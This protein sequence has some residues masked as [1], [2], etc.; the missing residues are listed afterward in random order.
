MCW[1]VKL[2]LTI[3]EPLVVSWSGYGRGSKAPGVKKP[4]VG[5][6][7]VAHNLIKAH[8]KVWH[9]YNEQ[10][11]SRQ[12]GEHCSGEASVEVGEE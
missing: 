4:E 9:T 6:Y 2:W 12:R 5:A 11:R 1:Q 8:A 3:N 10:Y 7:E